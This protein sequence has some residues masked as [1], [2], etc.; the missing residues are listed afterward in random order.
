MR[1]FSKICMVITC[2]LWLDKVHQACG[3]KVRAAVAPCEGLNTA[4]RRGALKGGARDQ[5][6]SYEFE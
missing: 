5:C 2:N 4:E 1:L 6:D 3:D